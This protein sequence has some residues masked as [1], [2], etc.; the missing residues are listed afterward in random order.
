MFPLLPGEPAPPADPRSPS[1]SP[2]A[3]SE[4][5]AGRA[6]PGPAA[7]AWLPSVGAAPPRE[8]LNARLGSQ[9]APA[10][11][12]G[13]APPRG[14]ASPSRPPASQPRSPP[15]RPRLASLAPTAQAS[16]PAPRQGSAPGAGPPARPP[17]P[18][19]PFR[20]APASGPDG[21]GRSRARPPADQSWRPRATGGERLSRERRAGCAPAHRPSRRHGNGA[22]RQAAALG[23]GV[24]AGPGPGSRRQLLPDRGP[25]GRVAAA[26]GAPRSE[27]G[28]AP[29]LAAA[30]RS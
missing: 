4:G 29:A 10:P 9:Q 27:Q 8:G 7:A 13:P 22:R 11:R 21:S 24:R 3:P 23:R 6:R 30:P 14:P 26:P 2:H 18:H 12:L 16:A 28:S 19:G 1:L 5:R 25:L 15:V 20:P 17:P